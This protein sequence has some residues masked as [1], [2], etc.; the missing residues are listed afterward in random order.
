M[1]TLYY[2]SFRSHSDFSL[3]YRPKKFFEKKETRKLLFQIISNF[4]LCN[5]YLNRDP[6]FWNRRCA[7]KSRELNFQLKI[8]RKRIAL[9][10][11]SI[12]INAILLQVTINIERA[13]QTPSSGRIESYLQLFCNAQVHQ[14]L[15]NKLKIVYIKILE[16]FD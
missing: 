6:C 4:F 1:N 5:L 15:N 8:C 9:R 16:L 11:M 7:P 12:L 13:G 3:S 10:S 2:Q 14:A